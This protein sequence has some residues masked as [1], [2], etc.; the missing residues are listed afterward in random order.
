MTPA[1]VLEST[2]VVG[3]APHSAS[4]AKTK[5]SNSSAKATDAAD[6]KLNG[7]ATVTNGSSANH[8]KLDLDGF[9]HPKIAALFKQWPTRNTNGEGSAFSSCSAAMRLV[10]PDLP[11]G[12]FCGLQLEIAKEGIRDSP[13]NRLLFA[14]ALA[15]A[16]VRFMETHFGVQCEMTPKDRER[17]ARGE[18]G[19]LDNCKL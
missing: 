18:L 9:F 14:R 8:A 12:G 4:L 11:N 15:L 6:V 16:L 10:Q 17:F 13:A 3:S 2:V 5:L 19:S 1:V 7:S